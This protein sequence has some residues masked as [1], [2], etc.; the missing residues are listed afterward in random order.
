MKITITIR[1]DKARAW[2]YFLQYKYKS[3]AGLDKLVRRALI[4]VISGIAGRY[5]EDNAI[6]DVETQ[7]TTKGD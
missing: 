6:D 4:E 2:L 1:D 3:K 7:G 5:I